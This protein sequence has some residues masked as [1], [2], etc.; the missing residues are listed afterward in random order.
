MLPV[1]K[2]LD[3]NH[4][5]QLFVT[6]NRILLA[7]S[8][9]KDSVLML[10]FFKAC[11]IDVGVAH[12][13]FK[14]RKDEAQ[15]DEHF[16]KTLAQ[17][18][19]LP[20]YVTHFDTKKYAEDHKIST[21]MAARALRY[22]WFEE[23]RTTHGYDYIALAQHQNDT[24][25]TVLINLIRGTGISGLHGILPK[26][27]KLIRPLLFL[28]RTEINHLVD[29][30][31]IS[32]VEDSSNAST[33]YVRNKLRLEV[34]PHLQNINPN[35]EHTFAKNSSRFADVE[36]FL[37]VQV[38]KIANEIVLEKADGTYISI[39]EIKILDPQKLLLFELLKPYGFLETVV[40]EIIEA[41]NKQS[42]IKFFSA[43]HQAT[44]NRDYLIISKINTEEHLHKSIHINDDEF[45]YNG[46]SFLLQFTDELKF[47][48]DKNKIFV[49][50]SAL[51][52][53]LIIRN[54]QNGD[55]FI[56]LGMRGFKKIS[57]FFIDEKVPLHIKSNVPI[58]V[59]GNGEIIWIVGMRQDNRYKLSQSTKKVAIFELKIK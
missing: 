56:P 45:E 9:G 13:N 30:N 57:D 24:I 2:F 22:S 53:P 3:F 12:C 27:D 33:D 39:D 15:R 7:V 18:L 4:H 16:V 40:E 1:Q 11:G 58:L 29:E 34:I 38:Q 26:R 48:A 44:I 51:Q 55:R 41:L 10:H 49:D 25:E 59:N 50:S 6:G 31:N 36:R 54:W 28:T 47:E 43:S 20:F 8:G 14:L 52:F 17:S 37:N 42:G 35:L 32:F 23:I 5:Q 21:Q 46:H 19:N